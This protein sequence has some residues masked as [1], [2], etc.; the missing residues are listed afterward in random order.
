VGRILSLVRDKAGGSLQVEVN[1]LTYGRLA[2]IEDPG[3]RRQVVEA[4]MELIQFTGVLGGDRVAPAPIEQTHSWREDLRVS[5]EAELDRIHAART[6][7]GSRPEQPVAEEEAEEQFLNLLTE[8]GQAPQSIERPSVMRAIQQRMTTQSTVEDDS[9]S[10]VN[11]IESIVQRSI[12][13]FP[14]LVGRD[15]HVRLAPDDSVCFVFEGQEYENLDDVPNLTARQL[16]KEAIQ[17]WED[18]T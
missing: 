3:I 11:E 16:I 12:L 10:F 4:A 9:R 17:E 14:A 6:G 8:M 7:K 15:L 18:T 13:L 2:D 5:S 1:G